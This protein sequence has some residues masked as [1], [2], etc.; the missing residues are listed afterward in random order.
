M[1][2]PFQMYNNIK[3]KKNGKEAPPGKKD[4]YGLLKFSQYVATHEWALC[5]TRSLPTSSSLA[6]S[7][8]KG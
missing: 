7:F 8:L 5:R 6:I 1:A 2:L 4:R 3:G